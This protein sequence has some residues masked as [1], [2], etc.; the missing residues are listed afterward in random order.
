M[1]SKR[2]L[3]RKEC[4]GKHAYQSESLARQQ[5]RIGTER[6]GLLL[7]AYEC[8]WGQHYHIGHPPRAWWLRNGGA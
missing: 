8:P 7:H 1:A 6:E 3:R 4:R 5:A 2:N